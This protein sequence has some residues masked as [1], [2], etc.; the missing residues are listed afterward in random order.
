MKPFTLNERG[1]VALIFALALPICIL[2]IVGAIDYSRAATTR[3]NLAQALDSVS[4]TLTAQVFACI[5]RRGDPKADPEAP[6]NRHCFTAAAEPD[7]ISAVLPP[8]LIANFHQTGSAGVPQIARPPFYDRATNSVRVAA[9]VS[10]TCLVLSIAR[11][12]EV[13]VDPASSGRGTGTFGIVG[14][15]SVELWLND[16]SPDLPA[17]FQ[18]VNPPGPPSFMIGGTRAVGLTVDTDTGSLSGRAAALPCIDP[19]DPE[20][21]GTLQVAA[22]AKPPGSA[23]RDVVSTGVA[24][25]AVHPLAAALRTDANGELVSQ[26]NGPFLEI[27]LARRG[28]KPPFSYS[29]DGAPN[30]IT[31]NPGSATLQFDTRVLRDDT[32][33][34]LVTIVDSRARLV[35]VAVSYSVAAGL[36]RFYAY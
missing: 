10:Y 23:R 15:K 13:S 26:R 14:P 30:G 19:C 8:L 29:A 28:G 11:P 7:D 20:P 32:G 36:G 22:E 33:T 5:T 34:V 35:S 3:A 16:Q 1:G 4:R 21:L 12:C 27:P 2:V 17:R 24:L 31:V 9:A 18:A 25:L 6:A